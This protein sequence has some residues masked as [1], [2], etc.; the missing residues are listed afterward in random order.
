MSTQTLERRIPTMRVRSYRLEELRT[1]NEGRTLSGY[2]AVFNQVERITGFFEDWDE[3][4]ARGAFT[5]TL[6]EKTPVMQF[7]HGRDPRTGTTPIGRYTDLQENAKGLKVRGDVFDNPITEPIR[8]AI[9]AGAI[10]G[11]SIRFEVIDEEIERR[12]DNVDL[13]TIKDVDLHEGGPVVFPAYA[14][15]SVSVR[16][17][18]AGLDRDEY[19]QLLHELADQAGLAVDLS[20]LTGRSD[21]QSADGGD[22][23]GKPEA[24]ESSTA[25]QPIEQRLTYEQLLQQQRIT[26]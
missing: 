6:G 20:S 1:E 9:S 19:R 13:R 3:K 4:F 11:M 7:D 18:L 2:L 26:R 24:G 15:T 23:D 10:S 25:T 17:M 22:P 5:R 8:Q 21:T 16:S 12:K 14:G